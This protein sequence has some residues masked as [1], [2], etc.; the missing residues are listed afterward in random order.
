MRN[1]KTHLI[2]ICGISQL[3]HM[4]TAAEVGA[5]L[6]GMV[7]VPGVRRKIDTITAQ[8]IIINFRKQFPDRPKIVGLFANQPIRTVNHISNAVGLDWLQ[9]CGQEDE[10]FWANIKRPFLQV[11]HV[12]DPPAE[13]TNDIVNNVVIGP[14]TVM[15]N[16]RF[17]TVA[18]LTRRLDQINQNGGL[19]LLDRE[20]SVQ[21]GGLGQP[22]DWT[23]AQELTENHYR[24]ILAGGLTPKNI[25]QALQTVQ[26]YGVDVSSG[27]ETDGKKDPEKIISFVQQVRDK[28]L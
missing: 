9:L 28:N 19:G 14:E 15:R 23:L 25:N 18:A 1:Q 3:E 10:L 11:V 22:F 21:P 12:P 13:G 2:K 27:V 5:D 26:P 8:K 20:S 17:S 16:Y 24:F 6:V 7:F 4:I